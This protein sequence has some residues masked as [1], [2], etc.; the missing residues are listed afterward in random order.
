MNHMTTFVLDSER[1]AG[2]LGRLFHALSANSRHVNY[3]IE[4]KTTRFRFF[5]ALRAEETGNHVCTPDQATYEGEQVLRHPTRNNLPTLLAYLS[6]IRWCY[7]FVAN[8]WIVGTW[9][10]KFWL[11]QERT[12]PCNNKSVTP[13]R[14]FRG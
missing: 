14:A 13:P 1:F 9:I 4:A 3:L 10:A 8:L 6:Q 5:R 12:A 2:L 11:S 7:R